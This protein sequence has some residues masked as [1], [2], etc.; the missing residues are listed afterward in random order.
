VAPGSG[1][2]IGVWFF[3]GSRKRTLETTSWAT[4][5]AAV[6]QVFLVSV[7]LAVVGGCGPNKAQL[8]DAFETC[9]DRYV[10]PIEREMADARQLSRFL[11]E[12]PQSQMLSAQQFNNLIVSANL[13]VDAFTGN[14]S[15]TVRAWDDYLWQEVIPVLDAEGAQQ[16]A[17]CDALY[18]D[19]W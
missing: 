17:E 14:G 5:C 6:R 18:A 12:L 1:D 2:R 15:A 13:R 19:R 9:K 11:E 7:L 10:D 8:H 16:Y 4:Y 3:W